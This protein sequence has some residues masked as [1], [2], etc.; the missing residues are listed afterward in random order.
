MNIAFGLT[1]SSSLF[2]QIFTT[3]AAPS[4]IAF[5][6]QDIGDQP[7]SAWVLQVSFGSFNT[8]CTNYAYTDCSFQA[9][10]LIQAVLNPIIGR[11]SDVLDRKMLVAV[12]PLIA[13]AGSVMSAK[14]N[15]MNILIAG[16]VLYGVTLATIGVVGTIPAEILPLKYRTVASG[17]SFLGGASGGLYV[18]LLFPNRG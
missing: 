3:V 4:T 16:G 18:T 1:H 15:D 2:M 6:V 17:I 10:L 11:L 13:F 12:T 14:A 8:H 7:M 9:P 5:I